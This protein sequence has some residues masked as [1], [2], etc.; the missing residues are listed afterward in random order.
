MRQFT[1][2]R[3]MLTSGVALYLA[4]LA[5]VAR[6]QVETNVDTAS[7]FYLSDL[8]PTVE[9]ISALP[10]DGKTRTLRFDITWEG[11]WRDDK[12]FDAAWVFFKVRAEGEK[13]W[14][15]ARLA[16]DKV[17]NPDGYGQDP[18]GRRIEFLVPDGADGFTGVMVQRAEDGFGA[19]IARGITVVWDFTANKGVTKDTKVEVLGM[20]IGMVYVPAGA[21]YLGSGGL[22][23]NGFFRYTDGSQQN[24]PYQVTSAGPI[25]TGRQSGKL[26]ARSSVPYCQP[27]TELEDNGKIPAS[28]PNGYPAF[29]F[30]KDPITREQY[31]TFLNAL[32]PEQ[33]AAR[34]N[35]KH[36]AKGTVLRTGQAPDYKYEVGPATLGKGEY[37]FTLI[38]GLN[39]ADAA[40]FASWAGL[41]PI[42]ELELEKLVRGPRDPI[43]YETGPSYWRISRFAEWDWF[44][45][46]LHPASIEYTVT[47]GPA[48]R[49]FTGTH[50][51]GTITLP[52]D[53]PQADGVGAGFRC[54]AR[55]TDKGRIWDL[56]GYRV[57]DRLDAAKVDPERYD[58]W[59]GARTAP[60]VNE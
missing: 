41:R 30:M 7:K 37:R 27:G 46:N 35:E 36:Q 48:G 12:N 38:D 15:H 17:F 50:G 43:P 55:A 59:R 16:A 6:A 24:Q 28:Y 33:S 29:Y 18:G 45:K 32:P 53:W 13:E 60:K 9:N 31:V 14:Q 25:P 19:V 47:A 51:N 3:V 20:A 5:G 1:I 39:W 4:M 23:Q 58:Q 22:E 42:T 10:R 40:M 34:W 52:A 44:S 57:S 2:S 49:K 56:Q 8:V 54:T 11:S 26:W 21:F